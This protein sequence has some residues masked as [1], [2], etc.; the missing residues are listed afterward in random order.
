MPPDGVISEVWHAAKWTK[1]MNTSR[2]SP[3][4]D[5]KQLQRHFY[6]NELSALKTGQLVVPVRW[7]MHN[8]ELRA[9][10]LE[11]TLDVLVR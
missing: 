2:L 3:M 10:A 11:V 1:A 8:G 4:Y 7:I 5:S 6:L 9:D